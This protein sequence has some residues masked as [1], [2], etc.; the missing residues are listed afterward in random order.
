MLYE[1]AADILH[2]IVAAPLPAARTPRWWCR[3]RR[4][5]GTGTLTC[6]DPGSSVHDRRDHEIVRC[7]VGQRRDDQELAVPVDFVPVDS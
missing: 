6:K 5:I 3:R 2:V 7:P 1:V 4:K